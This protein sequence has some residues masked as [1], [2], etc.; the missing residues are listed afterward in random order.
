MNPAITALYAGLLGLLYLALCWQVVDHR[1]KGR[2]GLG[3][4]GNPDLE[5]A[6]RVHGNFA[7]Y[8]PLFLVL[9]L[10]AELGGAAAWM[11]HALG[12]VFLVSRIGHAYG[13]SRSSG[14]TRGRFF[15]TLFTWIAL[16][17]AAVLNLWLALT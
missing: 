13:L 7:E 1:R 6:I 9:L 8:V 16:L 4:G 11:L 12:A 2:V 5:R 14:T 15:G 10:L 3:T 17:A